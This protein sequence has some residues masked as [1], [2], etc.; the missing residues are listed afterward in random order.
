MANEIANRLRA[1]VNGGRADFGET[2]RSVKRVGGGIGRDEID[3]TDKPCRAQPAPNGRAIGRGG[4]HGR[5]LGL[6]RHDD[7]I[8]VNEARVARAEPE[9]VRI[10]PN[11]GVRSKAMV[12]LRPRRIRLAK[13]ACEH[14]SRSFCGSSHDRSW[15]CAL[16]RAR[17]FWPSAVSPVMSSVVMADMTGLPPPRFS[18]AAPMPLALT[19]FLAKEAAGGAM[20]HVV[21]AFD[22]I[23]EENA[24]AVL[25]K[26][27]EL[28]GAR[29]RHHQPRHRPARLQ[30][31]AAHRR[32]RRQGAARRRA[33]L[34]R[35]D[36]DRA[37]ARGGRRRS[38][39]APRRRGLARQRADR[40]RRQG[41]DVYGDPDVRRARASTSSIPTPA[42]RSTAR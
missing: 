15:A 27:A 39:Q 14:R 24:F 17:I 23:G 30:N 31:A 18:P 40:A 2:E 21:S 28:A 7:P 29:P 12:R 38:A 35:R 9:E 26:A 4:G 10:R 19:G 42:F 41:H 20:L 8:H 37:S 25:A 3:L 22:R 34:Y 32:S 36:R 13:N 11:S 5:A 1:A 6:G 16:F 33:R